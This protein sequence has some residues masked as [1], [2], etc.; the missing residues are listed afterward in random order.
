M[1]S[2]SLFLIQCLFFLF[3]FGTSAQNTQNAQ[4]YLIE[5]FNVLGSKEQIDKIK[6]IEKHHNGHKHWIEQSENYDGPFITS[7]ED[8]TEVYALKE[9]L[10]HQEM[11]IKQFQFPQ[12]VESKIII[13]GYK[14][15]MIYGE[16]KYPVPRSYR[17]EIMGLVNYDPYILMLKAAQEDSL[18]LE[19]NVKVNKQIYNALSF[20]NN[21]MVHKLYFDIDNNYL[22]QASIETV[23]PYE[24]F[25]SPFGNFYTEIKYSLYNYYH[26]G[27][28]YPC[29]WD[30]YRLDK[31][32]RSI[33]I[34]KIEFKEVVD[35]KKFSAQSAIPNQPKVTDQ[36]ASFQL[37][38]NPEKGLYILKGQWF[39]HLIEQSNGIVVIESPISSSYS[40]SIVDYIK[41]KFPDKPI[42][43]LIVASDAY[44]HVAGIREYIANSVPIYTHRDNQELLNSIAFSDFKANPDTQYSVHKRP[45]YFFVD[46]KVTI[47][48]KKFPVSI[49]P[50]NG[51]AGGKMLMIYNDKSKWLYT[52]DLI[53]KL[54]TG[55]FFMPQYLTEV[56][57]AINRNGLKVKNA[58]AM[59]KLYFEWSEVIDYLTSFEK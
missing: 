30:I 34:D 4:N 2:K 20:T 51:T 15:D 10:L 41:T 24:N 25:F 13:N 1:T 28:R 37:L 48:D 56:L 21:N 32:W 49:F 18:N 38:D 53:Q 31:K 57:D 14:G 55:S 11:S 23:L 45:N 12:P 22:R 36:K 54:P 43:A 19:R 46:E 8:I 50:I 58:S 39:V 42:K 40:K 33:T 9:D 35:K 16:R 17:D 5:C 59:H 6:Y 52:A 27:L 7:Y 47:Q 29:Q 26:N 44:P 3:C